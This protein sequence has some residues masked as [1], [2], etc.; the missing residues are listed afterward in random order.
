MPCAFMILYHESALTVALHTCLWYNLDPASVN[1]RLVI[2]ISKAQILMHSI[3]NCMDGSRF[4]S[5]G[6]CLTV[7][8]DVG[9]G[10]C[11]YVDLCFHASSLP[12]LHTF[13]HAIPTSFFFFQ[14]EG[15][16]REILLVP[17]GL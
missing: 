7:V 12:S 17:F 6:C 11:Q 8:K 2:V 9:M 10:L 14:D 5:Q 15:H 1:C 16:G 4:S 13:W 3:D